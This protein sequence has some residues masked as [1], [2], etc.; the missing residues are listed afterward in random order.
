MCLEQLPF[1]H[2]NN[3]TPILHSTSYTSLELPVVLEQ[4]TEH[5]KEKKKKRE[6]THDRS[7]KRGN[8]TVKRLFLGL[9]IVDCFVSYPLDVSFFFF[10]SWGFNLCFL[11]GGCIVCL[12]FFPLESR[13]RER[14]LSRYQN[15]VTHSQRERETH[16]NKQIDSGVGNESLKKKGNR[17]SSTNNIINPCIN[18]IL[19]FKLNVTVVL[20]DKV[21]KGAFLSFLSPSLV[22]FLFS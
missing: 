20:L 9:G 17:S 4:G 22:L 12:C 2:F 8:E 14:K 5:P 19:D 3:H 7:R 18:R 10:S 1:F 15:L 13:E 6:T 16:T 21:G 11:L